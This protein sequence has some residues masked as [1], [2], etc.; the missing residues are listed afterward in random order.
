LKVWVAGSSPAMENYKIISITAL[1][2]IVSAPPTAVIPCKRSECAS[3]QRATRD[4]G[5]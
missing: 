5:F 4:D 3:I 1:V 2:T